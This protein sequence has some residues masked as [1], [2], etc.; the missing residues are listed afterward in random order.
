LLV[1]HAVLN[2]NFGPLCDAKVARY[3]PSLRKLRLEDGLKSGALRGLGVPGAFPALVELN[4]SVKF[5]YQGP[6]R[7]VVE[8]WSCDSFD[9]PAI[10]TL[11]RLVR[12]SIP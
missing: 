6:Q 10:S 4:I 5:H 1:C 7:P 11:T 9:L 3:A 12:F 8:Y 2:N